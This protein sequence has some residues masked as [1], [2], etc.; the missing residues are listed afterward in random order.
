[1]SSSEDASSTGKDIVEA[2]ASPFPTDA[3]V[4]QKAMINIKRDQAAAAGEEY[5]PTRLARPPAEQ[6]FDDCG[7]DVTSILVA[8]A[9]DSR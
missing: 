1:M 9:C 2:T 7:D 8:D 4:R 6:H 3:R 5:R